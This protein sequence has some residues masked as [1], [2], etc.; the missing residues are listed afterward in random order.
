[1]VPAQKLG[2][3]PY[4]G[5]NIVCE[6]TGVKV[7]SIEDCNHFLLNCAVEGKNF[8]CF[9]ENSYPPLKYAHKKPAGSGFMHI[10]TK[11]SQDKV[12]EL[13]IRYFNDILSDSHIT[14]SIPF[15]LRN[16][17]IDNV[18]S[19]DILPLDEQHIFFVIKET[20]ENHILG[21]V[22]R[23][24]I[25]NIFNGAFN[26]VGE[27]DYGR[28]ICPYFLILET[29]YG[30]GCT[31]HYRFNAIDIK[32]SS[33]PN[34]Q[35]IDNAYT[36]RSICL[37]AKCMCFIT[38]RYGTN[39]AESLII[40][41]SQRNSIDL[42]KNFPQLRNMQTS[43]LCYFVIFRLTEKVLSMMFIYNQQFCDFI[44]IENDEMKSARGQMNFTYYC[45]D[46][47]HNINLTE[48]F[49]DENCTVYGSSIETGG[50][51]PVEYMCSS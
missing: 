28:T 35:V 21:E 42:F 36:G 3:G 27:Y 33:H 51:G 43:H 49:H 6:E 22:P 30:S 1:M 16:N 19:G 12:S 26:C 29:L 46:T 10:Q 34:I 40:M 2:A 45:C 20:D 5:G 25:L 13:D 9:L 8:D 23:C 47:I 17:F 15:P 32:K 14:L 44:H 48:D 18:V 38:Y 39:S 24:Y 4:N 50:Y 41:D 7:S 37:N 31:Y 11:I